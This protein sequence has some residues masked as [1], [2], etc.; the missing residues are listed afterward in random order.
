MV[1]KRLLERRCLAA[2]L[3]FTVL[4]I[5]LPAY[6]QELRDKPDLVVSQGETAGIASELA[7]SLSSVSKELSKE[8]LAKKAKRKAKIKKRKAKQR[9]KQRTLRKKR[10]EEEKAKKEYAQSI[11][12]Y[13]ECDIP[14]D[15]KSTCADIA[16]QYGIDAYVLEAICFVETDC[17]NYLVSP[18][19][20]YGIMQVVPRYHYS[21]MEKLGVS[22]LTDNYSCILVGADYLHETLEEQ[23]GSYYDA[24][25]VY[26]T[27]HAGS[28]S[29]ASK[30]M[31]IAEAL[32]T[33]EE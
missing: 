18:H 13:Y 31:E 14:S 25:S 9:A 29:Y 32:K 20:A 8:E 6:A 22:D 21:R 24:L 17:K 23:G 12:D 5:Q 33:L 3:A 2:S 28:T 19:G 15:V 26:N 30:V 11:L 4:S 16:N 1:T 10:R 27:G 7:N